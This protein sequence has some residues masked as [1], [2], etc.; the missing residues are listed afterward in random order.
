MNPITSSAATGSLNPASP[1]SVRARRRR[2]VDPR[3][4]AKIAAASVEA[5]I[6]PSNMPSSVERSSSQAAASPVITAVAMVPTTASAIAGRSTGRIS[7]KPAASPPSK[8]IRASAR[9]PMSRS[10][11]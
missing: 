5:T 9:T 8:M 3:S 4:T 6:E 1:S 7:E 10:S 11:S 2:S